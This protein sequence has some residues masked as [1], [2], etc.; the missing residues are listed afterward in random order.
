[1]KRS[2]VLRLGALSLLASIAS[3]Q[4]TPCPSGSSVLSYRWE[5]I[6][7]GFS[8]IQALPGTAT[9]FAS[10]TDDASVLVPFPAG[11]AFSYFGVAKTEV[12]VCSNGFASF[13]SASTT[14]LN[15][16]PGDGEVPNDAIF[17]WHDDLVLVN[18][19]SAVDVRFDLAPGA[20]RATIEWRNVGNF[21]STGPLTGTGSFTFQCVLYASTHAAL[22]G[23]IDFRYDRT[24]APPVMMPCQAAAG[25]GASTYA[26]SATVGCEDAAPDPSTLGVDAIERG[27][28]NEYFPE[29][30]LRLRP[31]SFTRAV[32]ASTSSLVPQE[33]FCHIEGLPGTVTVPAPPPLCG[34]PCFDDESSAQTSGLLLPFPAAAPPRYTWRS[35]SHTCRSSQNP[36][37]FLTFGPG[38]FLPNF[39]NSIPSP[40]EPDLF[41][42]P[43][44]DDLEGN[45]SSQMVYRV[46]GTPGCRVF[47]YEW[48]DFGAFSFPGGDC[49]TAGGSISMQVKIFEGSAGI[50]PAGCPPLPPVPGVGNDRIEFHYDH[51]G[52]VPGPFSASI[53]GE[54]SN[55]SLSFSCVP[56]NSIA[57][58]P[59]GMKCVIAPCDFGSLT[60]YGD[61]TTNAVSPS[62][63]CFP[64][65]KTN[66][67]PPI[68]GNL[69]GLRVVG[70]SPSGLAYLLLEAGGA[71]PGL[72]T[73]VFCGGI[74]VFPP[75]TLW[76]PL[77]PTL[78]VS[79]GLTTPGGPC[80]GGAFLDL[81]IPP[82]AGL[83]GAVLFA[84]WGVVSFGGFGLR[85]ELTEGTKIVI[86]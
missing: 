33:P 84:Q 74:P 32:S 24:G 65:I 36:N 62:P 75:A 81:P 69:F 43:F 78:I 1:M 51:A 72:K 18:P 19:T 25:A 37:G 70:G 20:E 44:W 80:G 35:N 27:A 60:D 54:T 52:F 64:R 6:P 56:G 4:T 45:P 73:P 41:V 29:C 46:D 47:T 23:V 3:A 57:A 7:P 38:S 13:T 71:I 67:V 31:T 76:V 85:V 17:P 30:D 15:R 11:F 28:S 42:A 14:A 66:G 48:H 26:T 10:P 79:P 9:L 83:G 12:R 55:G 53:G 22:P 63:L 2:I 8:S 61:P 21:V 77:P 58:P 39:A 86:G 50:Q 40:S 34:G 5:P 68:Q 59:A 49:A 16:H 82:A